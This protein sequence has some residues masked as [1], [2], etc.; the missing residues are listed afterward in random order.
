MSKNLK[1]NEKWFIPFIHITT[2]DSR[3]SNLFSE[4]FILKES[5]MI[6]IL[7]IWMYLYIFRDR[8]IQI[9]YYCL[10]LATQKASKI[11][12]LENCALIQ[13]LA[14][15]VLKYIFSRS[16]NSKFE[17][18]FWFD[19]SES[20]KTKI[21]KYRT[22]YKILLEVQIRLYPWNPCHPKG[23]YWRDSPPTPL[24]YETALIVVS[25]TF[26]ILRKSLNSHLSLF[27]RH[28]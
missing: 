14:L 20:P 12:I 8:W 21:L 4:N 16:L 22:S 28:L 27:K 23:L 9:W 2:L 24:S 26:E 25:W 1:K 15:L 7:F 11:K 18:M 3:R 5:K 19:P 13:T 6:F 17:L 10:K